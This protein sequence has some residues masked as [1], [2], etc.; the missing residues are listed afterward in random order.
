MVFVSQIEQK[1]VNEALIDEH[2]FLAMQEE[3]NQFKKNNVW[4]LIPKP[5][6]NPLI[7]TKWVFCNKFDKNGIVLVNK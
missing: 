3:L 1:D 7:G 6:S 2:W 4:E 5:L